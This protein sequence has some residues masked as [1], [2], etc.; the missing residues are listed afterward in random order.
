MDLEPKMEPK[1]STLGALSPPGDRVVSAVAGNSSV[2]PP[3]VHSGVP[4]APH[5]GG[6]TAQLGPD[7]VLSAGLMGPGHPVPPSLGLTRSMLD[8]S[9][10]GGLPSG[11]G[12]LAAADTTSTGAGECCILGNSSLRLHQSRP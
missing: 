6:A 8:G 2:G 7:G 10:C 4:G 9:G 5:F 3:G 1:I 11:V 12:S